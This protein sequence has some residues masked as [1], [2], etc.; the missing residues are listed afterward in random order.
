MSEYHYFLSIDTLFVIRTDPRPK[1]N[2]IFFH[3]S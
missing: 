3:N 1:F 2:T